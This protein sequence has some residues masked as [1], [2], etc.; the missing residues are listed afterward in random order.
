M[1][2]A[3]HLIEAI[4]AAIGFA[5]VLTVAVGVINDIRVR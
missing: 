2:A 4:L 3:A 1:T 5:F